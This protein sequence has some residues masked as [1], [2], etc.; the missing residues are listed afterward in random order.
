MTRTTVDKDDLKELLVEALREISGED[1][2][3]EGE[4]TGEQLA[5]PDDRARGIMALDDVRA[6]EREQLSP[7]EYVQ[8]EHGVDP[9]EFDS[10]KSLREAIRNQEAA[11]D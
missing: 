10:Y 8:R 3:T 1:A 2:H 4:G 6:M 5:T 9:A 11:D 7:R